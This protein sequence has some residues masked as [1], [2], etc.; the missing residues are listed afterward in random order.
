MKSLA[1]LIGG[2][3]LASSVSAQL[4][5]YR[6]DTENRASKRG[7]L[8][9]QQHLED[10]KF[11]FDGHALAKLECSHYMEKRTEGK[12]YLAYHI[13]E[14]DY[15]VLLEGENKNQLVKQAREEARLYRAIFQ[16]RLP[17]MDR[18]SNYIIEA[19]EQP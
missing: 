15:C 2:L 16:E 13:P 3:L 14:T 11:R 4:Y 12:L 7:I 6:S 8:P 18:N 1:A 10:S 17:S 19:F 9:V 5:A